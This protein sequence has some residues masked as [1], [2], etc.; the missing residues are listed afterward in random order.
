MNL[1]LNG[2]TI[3][4]ATTMATEDKWNNKGQYSKNRIKLYEQIFGDGYISAGGHRTTEQMCLHLQNLNKGARVLDI[5]SGI[6]GVAFFLESQYGCFVTGVDMCED[7]F[8]IAKEKAAIKR[9]EVNFLLG[10]I[11]NMEFAPKSFDVIMSRDTLLHL[12]EKNK[13]ELFA[14]CLEWLDDNGEIIIGDYCRR[15]R[16]E[17][18]CELFKAYV[19]DRGYDLHEP[20]VYGKLLEDAGFKQVEAWDV[21]KNFLEM[22]EVELEQFRKKHNP[23]PENMQKVDFDS[24]EKSWLEKIGWVR[25][26]DMRKGILYGKQG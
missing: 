17:A 13:R 5:G 16:N 3:K 24:F 19:D 14:R 7:V 1:K 12:P 2:H 11:L 10:D 20:F 26:G 4:E 21:S 18:I 22:L 25:T 23:K 8:T 9:S 6:G 15:S